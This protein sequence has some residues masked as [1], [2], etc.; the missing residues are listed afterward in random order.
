MHVLQISNGAH[1]TTRRAQT[2]QAAEVA[3]ITERADVGEATPAAAAKKPGQ[4]STLLDGIFCEVSLAGPER[5]ADS[6]FDARLHEIENDLLDDLFGDQHGGS[7]GLC[8][9]ARKR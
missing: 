2:T 3:R 1:L 6:I 7:D 5:G 9:I 4:C 8:R